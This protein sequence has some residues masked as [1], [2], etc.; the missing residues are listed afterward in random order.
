MDYQRRAALSALTTSK[1][2][3]FGVMPRL[4]IS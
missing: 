4:A 3:W 1:T 2:S